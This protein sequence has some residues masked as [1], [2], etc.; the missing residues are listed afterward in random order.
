MQFESM[1]VVVNGIVVATRDSNISLTWLGCHYLPLGPHE[2]AST[3]SFTPDF[4][5]WGAAAKNHPCESSTLARY[6]MKLTF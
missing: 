1:G 2:L 4:E 5:I 6:G 3:E